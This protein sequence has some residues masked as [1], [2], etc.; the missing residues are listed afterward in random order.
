[1]I[2][3]TKSLEHVIKQEQDI[4]IHSCSQKVQTNYFT[5]RLHF[6]TDIIQCRIGKNILLTSDKIYH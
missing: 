1:M 5:N 3:L 6:P 4:L 2:Q